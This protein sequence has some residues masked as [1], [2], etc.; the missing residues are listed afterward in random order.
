MFAAKNWQFVLHSKH[1]PCKLKLLEL[2]AKVT[3]GMLITKGKYMSI[4]YPIVIPEWRDLVTGLGTAFDVYMVVDCNYGYSTV[5]S[6][7]HV[8]FRV[9]APSNLQF[10]SNS[11]LSWMTSSVFPAYYYDI[12]GN[13]NKLVTKLPKVKRN[14]QSF[15]CKMNSSLRTAIDYIHYSLTI[16]REITTHCYKIVKIGLAN[17]PMMQIEC[18]Q[19]AKILNF[20]P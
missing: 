4:W 2:I 13:C 16:L 1:S 14:L 18:L 11:P 7:T 9:S 10:H 19:I 17:F 12:M 15:K 8:W 3:G 5:S 6:F 20:C